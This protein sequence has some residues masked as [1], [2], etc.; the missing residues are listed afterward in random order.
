M[1]LFLGLEGFLVDHR[2]GSGLEGGGLHLPL[3]LLLHLKNKNP[4]E[5]KMDQSKSI[6]LLNHLFVE[7]RFFQDTHHFVPAVCLHPPPLIHPQLEGLRLGGE[8]HLPLREVHLMEVRQGLGLELWYLD[9][10]VR[11]YTELKMA[12]QKYANLRL[13]CCKKSIV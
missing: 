4:P 2:V 10:G 1:V 7:Q 5:L 8:Q 6:H 3:L 9:P 11:Q 13:Y 12:I